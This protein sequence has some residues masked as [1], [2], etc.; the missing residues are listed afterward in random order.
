M[1]FKNCILVCLIVSFISCESSGVPD[2][3]SHV[4]GKEERIAFNYDKGQ[5]VS[6]IDS[7]D[8]KEYVWDIADFYGENQTWRAKNFIFDDDGKMLFHRSNSGDKYE[9]VCYYDDFNRLRN[10]INKRILSTGEVFVTEDA[11]FIYKDSVLSEISNEVINHRQ[12][13]LGWS[14]KTTISYTNKMTRNKYVSSLIFGQ[15]F[16]HTAP[17]YLLASGRVSD[18]LIS[19]AIMESTDGTPATALAFHYEFDE[20]GNVVQIEI[21]NSNGKAFDK[22]YIIEYAEN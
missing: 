21:K 10:V 1:L 14:E 9:T 16:K 17:F 3:I 15:V 22:R 18:R 5:L 2:R 11:K 7:F 4:S 20:R 19:T 6:V 12:K 8:K 13:N